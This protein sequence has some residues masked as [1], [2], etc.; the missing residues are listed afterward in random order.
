MIYNYFT[1]CI[2]VM[3]EVIQKYCLQGP[4][5]EV[6]VTNLA[7]A[8]TGAILNEDDEV[9]D[10]IEDQEKVSFLLYLYLLFQFSF[11]LEA[12]SYKTNKKVTFLH[13]T[14][15]FRPSIKVNTD[16]VLYV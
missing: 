9:E 2:S 13:Q 1:F 5:Y 10:F 14:I 11:R 8:S 7:Y 15:T 12:R 3:T 6:V 4:E 16:V